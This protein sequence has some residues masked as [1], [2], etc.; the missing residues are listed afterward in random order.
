MVGMGD[1][2]VTLGTDIQSRDLV[3]KFATSLE[4]LEGSGKTYY[5]LN[6]APLPIVYINIGD[7]DAKPFLYELPEERRKQIKMFEFKADKPKEWT[8]QEC[9]DILTTLSEIAVK[10]LDENMVNG[11]F[12][13]DSGSNWWTAVQEALVAP[14]LEKET[15]RMG[16]LAYGPGNLNVQGVIN[17]IKSRGVFLMLTHKLKDMWDDQGPIPGKYKPS[18][19]SQVP[20]LVEVRLTLTKVCDNCGAPACEARDHS[21]RKHLARLTR[22]T[23]PRPNGDK[24]EGFVVQEPTFEMI[25]KFY[26]G[27]DFPEMERLV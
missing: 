16:G 24:L 23:P 15:K 4:G 6:T 1:V 22:F 20:F 9:L 5:I 10:E 14:Q 21:G 13:I 8:R 12:A 18:I 27:K 19:N 2:E 17:F 26:T 25:Y 3:V 7:R 11:T